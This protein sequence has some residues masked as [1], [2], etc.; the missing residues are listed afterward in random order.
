[1]ARVE[2]KDAWLLREGKEGK[3]A[4][5]QEWNWRDKKETNYSGK[6]GTE[7]GGKLQGKKT[8]ITEED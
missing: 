5:L 6:I 1:M 4:I 2:E 7:R 8:Y 3:E